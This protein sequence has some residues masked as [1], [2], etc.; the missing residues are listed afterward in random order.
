M[1]SSDNFLHTIAITLNNNEN[2]IQSNFI[3]FNGLNG[4]KTGGA[5]NKSVSNLNDF[6]SFASRNKILKKIKE[7]NNKKSK[8]K[9][10]MNSIKN[11]KVNSIK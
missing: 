1:R 6:S 7:K 2:T 5:K 10:K 9:K 3:R 8:K 11:K 4:G